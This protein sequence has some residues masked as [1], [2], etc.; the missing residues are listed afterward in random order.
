MAE[1]GV[2]RF[3]LPAGPWASLPY[4]A[5]FPPARIAAAGKKRTKTPN[6]SDN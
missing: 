1:T 6:N 4:F 5:P 2:E 3:F